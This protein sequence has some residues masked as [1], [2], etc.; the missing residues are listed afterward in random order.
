MPVALVT[1]ASRGIGKAIA[2]SLAAAGF[3]VAITARTVREGEGVDDSEAVNRPVVGSL[4]TTAALV[5][6]AGRRTLAVAADLL[7]RAS[8]T[9]AV[10]S[11]LEQWGAIDVLVNNAVHTG[12]GNM[13]RFAD[14]TLED[15]ET[16]LMANAVA[17]VLLIKRVLP[18]MLERG[19]GT[20]IN[21]TSHVATNDPPAPAGE[22]GWG[23]AYAMSKGALHRVAGVLAV[24]FGDR[25]I[26]AYNVDPG[27]VLTE[28]MLDNQGDL[29]LEG[30]YRGAPPSVIGAAV[31]WLATEEAATA[32]L[33]GQ[34][35]RG[36]K[37]AL[38]LGLHPDWRS[39]AG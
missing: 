35:V 27:F 38:E 2:L 24:E 10:D 8:L 19:R 20:V 32:S 7:D 34:T 6:Q 30:R 28:R 22:G 3:D 33:N 17:P 15:I 36:Q 29:G 25:G 11:V 31:A 37:V 23:L 1:G 14:L 39:R 13:E 16:K 9:A 12:R 4:E 5:E 18:G 21:I 26:R